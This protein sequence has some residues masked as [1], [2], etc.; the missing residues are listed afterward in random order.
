MFFGRLAAPYFC[1][2]GLGFL[3]S[4]EFYERMVRE[5]ASTDPVTLN[6]SGAVHL[7]IGLAVVV[8]H[9]RFG[10]LL[11][12]LITLIGI[13]ALVKGSALIGVPELTLKSPKTGTTT[14]RVSGVAF[15]MVGFYLGFVSY[16]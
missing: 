7:L 10:S 9:F 15:V 8:Q 6:L 4:T 2:T 13:A 3:V 16:L 5:N 12:T 14:L 1:V 11:E